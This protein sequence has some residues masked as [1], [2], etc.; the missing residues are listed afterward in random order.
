MNAMRKK[1]KGAPTSSKEPPKVSNTQKEE[2][3]SR[4]VQFQ[5]YNVK[6]K[7]EG[8]IEGKVQKVT[9]LDLSNNMYFFSPSH[10]TAP[11]LFLF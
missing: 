3:K 6:K 8:K 9:I 1:A 7:S 10:E 11:A 2:K 4:F 5:Y